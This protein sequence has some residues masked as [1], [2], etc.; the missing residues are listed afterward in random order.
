VVKLT[1]EI[2]D[3]VARFIS[4]S[5]EKIAKTLEPVSGPA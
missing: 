1:L 2:E 4:A 5:N 3:D